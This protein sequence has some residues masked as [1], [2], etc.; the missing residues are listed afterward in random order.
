MA[1]LPV[2]LPTNAHGQGYSDLNF[3][4]P[5]L[6]TGVQFRKGPYAADEGDFSA[7]GAANIN[8]A[9]VLGHP[10]ID[11]S[12][13]GEGWSRA[14]LAASPAVARGHLLAALELNHNDGPWTRPDDYRKVNGVLRYSRGD[15]RNALSLTAMAYDG[16]WHSTDQVPDRAI[17]S[18]LIS[19]FGEIDPADGGR[20]ARYSAIAD[21]EHTSAASLTHATVFASRYRL[22][23]F[24]DFT[25]F[26][27]DPERGDQFEQA[28][29]RWT[30]GGRL[31]HKRDVRWAGRRGENT[32]GLE[33]RNDAIPLVGLYHTEART[34]LDAI[35]E[36]RV[37]EASG[38][39]FAENA[40]RWTPWLR[41]MAGVRLDGYRFRVDSSDPAN[42]GTRTAGLVSPRGGLVLGPWAKT[43]L[44]VNAGT[45]FHSNDARGATI[46]RDP[47]TGEPANPV[48]PLVRAKGAEAGIR[49]VAIPHTQSTL[50]VWRLDLASELV[51]AGDAGVTEA[52]RPGR[53][54]GVEWTNYVHVP[55]GL[56]VDADVAWSHARFTDVDPAGTAIPGSAGVVA[57]FGVTAETRPVFGSVRL[58]YFGPRPL[59]ED[60]H[61]RSAATGLVNAQVGCR[62]GRALR[63]VLDAFNLLEAAASDIDYYY[64]SRLPGEPA[65]GVAD[66]HSHPTIPRT[67]RIG[68]NVEF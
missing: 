60:D 54:Y 28:D 23:L 47:S 45:G 48:T 43:E 53:R 19:R 16:R 15:M 4:I 52:S 14:L 65:D 67:L 62:I 22:N 10:Q 24:S 35:R 13:G 36:D 68:M 21:F 33:V 8:Y 63:V 3:L 41:T 40:L 51:F 34:R 2:N 66:V 7:A 61:V 37:D 1:G 5:E 49:S 25:Y 50:T 27:D 64:V 31:T 55:A 20:T 44:Y 39:V 38:A 18:G 26:L 56:T 17:A 46:T 9:T 12:G 42:S 30:T 32:F 11:V 58:R 59:I 6:V 57:S 29:R